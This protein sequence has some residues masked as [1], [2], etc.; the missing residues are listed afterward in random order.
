MRKDQKAPFLTAGCKVADGT[1]TMLV[2][3]TFHNRK[4][5]LFSLLLYFTCEHYFMATGDSAEIKICLRL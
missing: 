3:L 4:L 2:K 1:G 5:C